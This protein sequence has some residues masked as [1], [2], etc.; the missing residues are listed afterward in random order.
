M[1]A[2][3]P[4]TPSDAY[5]REYLDLLEPLFEPVQDH[6]AAALFEFV[7]CL[8]HP[9]GVE[10]A[11]DNPLLE[12]TALIDDLTVFSH[13]DLPA[14]DFAHP[15]RT[16]ARLAL[17]SYCHLTEVDFFYELLTNL[18]RVRCGEQW[19]LAPFADLA[20]MVKAK[21]G[22]GT[23]KRRPPSPKTKIKRIGEYA[24]KAGMPQISA[25]FKDIY[26]SEIRNAVFHADYTVSGTTFHINRD[27]YHPPHGY[28]T[29][30]VPLSEILTIVERSFAFYYALL[31]RHWAVAVRQAGPACP[32]RAQRCRS[33]C[34]CPPTESPRLTDAAC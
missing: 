17:L 6:N 8:V 7:C 22:M 15:E 9:T 13:Q 1:L 24:T 20:R 33:R 14:D 34:R 18:L 2:T 23:E 4:D 16:R 26:V 27:Y 10:G 25:V 30:D 29:R 3:G 31:N 28:L 12:S 21:E 19:A 11:E 5:F 32:P